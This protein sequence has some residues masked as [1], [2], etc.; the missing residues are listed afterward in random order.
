[1]SQPYKIT[2]LK[3]QYTPPKALMRRL[4]PGI[5]GVYPRREIRDLAA[6]E[7]QFTLFIHALQAIKQ[8]D[9]RPKAARFQDLGTTFVAWGA[10]EIVSRD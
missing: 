8:P 3:G 9:Y 1:M 7:I 4:I 6:D 5:V 2:G 10:I